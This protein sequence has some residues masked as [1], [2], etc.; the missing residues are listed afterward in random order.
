M[1]SGRP[2]GMKNSHDVE[3]SDSSCM[4]LPLDAWERD[5]TEAIGEIRRLGLEILK[6]HSTVNGKAAEASTDWKLEERQVEEHQALL[7][8]RTSIGAVAGKLDDVLQQMNPEH[9]DAAAQT[10]EQNL[11]TIEEAFLTVRHAALDLL[12]WTRRSGRVENSPLPDEYRA[13]YARLISHTPMI[14]P[15]LDALQ[16]ELL[17]RSREPEIDP[18]VPK[19]LSAITRYNGVMDAARGF[20]RAIVD[21]PLE[22]TFQETK[23]FL[24][25]WNG[26]PVKTRAGL[27][28][29]LN[30]CCQ[31]LL[32]DQKEFSQ[33]V[34]E[35][36]PDL[37][38]GMDASLY[39]MLIGGVRVLFSVD[40][41]P[42]FGLLMVT[43]YR[44]VDSGC[45]DEVCETVTAS[46]YH[47]LR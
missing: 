15:R 34:E 36:R 4:R 14:K 3:A 21:P 11:P 38:N 1:I 32:Y 2:F 13:S 30:D 8:L 7:S 27:A 23:G 41:D 44:A 26:Y 47:E 43:L 17:E 22:L 35:I 45:Y 42:L 9:V 37:A 16:K 18:S 19:L 6:K 24:E 40:E 31:F 20:V 29:E 5:M 46:L 39:S 12:R 33:R 28:T 10:I 25:D